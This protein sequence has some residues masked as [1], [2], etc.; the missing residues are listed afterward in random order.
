MKEIKLLEIGTEGGSLTFYA[1]TGES[2][3]DYVIGSYRDK[4]YRTDE[5][6][7]LDYSK[8]V[9]RFSCTTQPFLSSKC[10]FKRRPQ[11]HFT[12]HGNLSAHICDVV[13]DQIQP[14]SLAVSV[15]V[16][17]LVQAK[18]FVYVL[19]AVKPDSVI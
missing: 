9:I 14:D 19:F 6:M 17:G 7:L 3:T 10:N 5:E 12:L 4:T 13:V 15:L 18:H 16:E 2:K 8:I 11:I 1:I